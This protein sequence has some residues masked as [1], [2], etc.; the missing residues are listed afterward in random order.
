M[1]AEM[2][3]RNRKESF[4]L[5]I[6]GGLVLIL[7]AVIAVPGQS[8]F[9]VSGVVL[10]P[11]GAVIADAKIILRRDCGRSAETKT[12]NQRGEFH[13]TRIASGD[14]EIEVQKEGFK[15]IK[16]RVTVD[17]K[18]SSPLQI[19]L[20]IAD[21]REEIAVA[22]RPN[23]VNTNPDE[24]LDVIKLDRAALNNLPVLG[25]D[26]IGSVANLLDAG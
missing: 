20:P 16:T 10:D 8:P 2:Q 5:R 17:A 19:V 24:N 14:Y 7:I 21:V 26:V 4:G 1:I 15:P 23:Q 9:E 18:S 11:N 12:A 3:S 25:N 13:F 22:D 6:V